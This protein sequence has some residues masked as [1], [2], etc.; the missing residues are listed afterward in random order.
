MGASDRRA[1]GVDDADR[2]LHWRRHERGIVALRRHVNGAQERAVG[3]VQREPGNRCSRRQLDTALGDRQHDMMAGGAVEAHADVQSRHVEPTGCERHCEPA[4]AA[5]HFQ[6]Q[7]GALVAVDTRRQSTD[8]CAA[9]AFGR[10]GECDVAAVGQR[11]RD[12]SAARVG[13]RA[14]QIERLLQVRGIGFGDQ[15][16]RSIG[17]R[18]AVA[19]DDVAEQWLPAL[20]G[21][22]GRSEQQGE[23]DGAAPAHS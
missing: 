14:A 13:R 10:G 17:D 16:H 18:R 4:A 11:R 1:P 23:D 8:E 3:V 2:E 9:V 20:R 15:G 6:P 22:D 21:Q 5:G 12:E 19:V 7:H